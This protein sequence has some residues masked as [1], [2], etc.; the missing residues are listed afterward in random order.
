MTF[1]NVDT[2]YRSHSLHRFCFQLQIYSGGEQ[3]AWFCNASIITAQLLSWWHGTVVECRSLANFPCPA[4]DLRLMGT[5]NVG[6][7]SATGQPTRPTQPFILSGS[8][9]E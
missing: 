3:F 7:P 9:N 8:I 2:K 6:K 4:L 5:I 1:L